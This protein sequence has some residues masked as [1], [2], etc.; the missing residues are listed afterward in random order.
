MAQI[1][2]IEEHPQEDG[3]GPID[4]HSYGH[5]LVEYR[6]ILAASFFKQES[7]TAHNNFVRPLCDPSSIVRVFL[8]GD[9]GFTAYRDQNDKAGHGKEPWELEALL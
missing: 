9:G 6:R 8:T 4:L 3:V 1:S 2:S 7:R 5:H